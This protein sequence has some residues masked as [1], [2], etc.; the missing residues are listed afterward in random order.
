MVLQLTVNPRPTLPA[1]VRPGFSEK[2]LSIA[3][4]L[5]S[6]TATNQPQAFE[7]GS[8]TVTLEGHRAS[9]RVQHAGGL[10]GSTAQLAI[11]GLSQSIQDQLSTLGMVI[12]LVPRNTIT[13][14]AGDDESGMSTVFV[15]IIVQAIP[16]FSG[17]PTVPFR[18]ELNSQAAGLAIPIPASSYTGATDVATVLSAL[19]KQMGWG[20]ENSGVSVMLSNPYLAGSAVSA[21]RKVASAA[22]VNWAV[23][24]NVL[25]V[26][27]KYGTRRG[28]GKPLVAPPPAGQMIGFPSYTQ[29]GIKVSN[30]FD[31][32]I[33]QGGQVEV[34]SSLKRASGTWNVGQI[35]LALDQLVPKGEWSTTAWCYNPNFP[36][37]LPGK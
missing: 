21:I 37:P 11:W 35:D 29:Q 18:F 13:I 31:P 19:A 22:N 28:T 23:L 34:R 12:Q 5:A 7:N 14:T 10:A 6:K 9:L 15:G 36:Q 33:V 30:L 24:N 1:P 25:C 16:D 8:N 17:V 27:P 4:K 3:I 20:F 32:R 2:K 26:W